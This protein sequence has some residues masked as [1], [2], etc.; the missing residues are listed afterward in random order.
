MTRLFGWQSTTH[1]VDDT[2]FDQ[3]VDT[4]V[5]DEDMAG[6]FKE[7]NPYALEEMTRRLLEANSRGLWKTDEKT[8]DDLKKAYLD[9]ESLL[10]DLAGEG[11]FQGGS[12]DIF[13]SKDVPSWNEHMNNVA[14]ITRKIRESKQKL[15]GQ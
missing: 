9:V 6:F 12:V 7:N 1:E 14:D 4:F 11:E 3:V 10:E 8:L 5:R 2:L 15:N 13:D